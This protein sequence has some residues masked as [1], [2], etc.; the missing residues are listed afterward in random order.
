[1]KRSSL[2]FTLVE[3]MVAVAIIGIAL[4]SLLVVMMGHIDGSAWLRDKLQAQWVA[5]NRLTEMRLRYQRT[6]ELDVDEKSGHEE[7]AGRDWYWKSRAKAFEQEEFEDVY[8]IE[9]SVWQ[10]TPKTKDDMPLVTVVGI[11][12][13]HTEAIKRPDPEKPG[14]ANKENTDEKAEGSEANTARQRR[15]RRGNE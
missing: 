9:V 2:G 13:H 6:G 4:P 3:V 5:E 7:L 8:G 15:T 11:L 10:E 1:M 12:H 14:E